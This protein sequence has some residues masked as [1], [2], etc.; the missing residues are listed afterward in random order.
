MLDKIIG[1]SGIGNRGNLSMGKGVFGRTGV[2][3]MLGWRHEYFLLAAAA[4]AFIIFVVVVVVSQ[5][6]GSLHP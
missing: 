5:D 4:A 3:P 1:R 2:P 6:K